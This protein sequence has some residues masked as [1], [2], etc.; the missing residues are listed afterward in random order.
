MRPAHK[1]RPLLVGRFMDV[2]LDPVTLKAELKQTVI[3]VGDAIVFEEE[4]LRVD[5][6]AAK[7]HGSAVGRCGEAVKAI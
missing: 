4:G 1:L 3:V 6:R 5:P 7:R 2:D